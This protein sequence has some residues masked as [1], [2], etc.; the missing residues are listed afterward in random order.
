MITKKLGQDFFTSG[1]ALTLNPDEVRGGVYLKDGTPQKTHESGWTIRGRIVKDY[2][3]WVNEFEAVH[4]DYG[5]V[6]GNFEDEVQATSEEAFD[7][8]WEHHEPVD[9]DYADI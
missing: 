7:H 3:E 9:W 1:G 2:F 6:K 8:F 4:I 5:F